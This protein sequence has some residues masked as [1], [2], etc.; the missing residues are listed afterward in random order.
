MGYR[1]IE[2]YLR[3]GQDAARA[4]G[5]PSV[6]GTPSDEGLQ[7][8]MSALLRTFSDFAGLWMDLMGKA[9]TGGAAAREP[10]VTPAVGTAGPFSTPRP[11]ED[12]E[13]PTA[14]PPILT[15]DIESARRIEVSVDLRI[16]SSDLTLRVHDLRA[17]ELDVPRIT[18]VTIEAVPEEER[19]AIRLRIPDDQP[20][21]IYNG[22]ILDERTGL[23]RGT[24][25][26]RIP[27]W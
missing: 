12:P 11:R 6:G 18:G 8:R 3:Q 25:C 27:P 17:P 16:R 10:G 26:V 9:S 22:I 15:L 14:A 2:E 20:S 23:P 13:G 5:V 19:V 1:V 4:M 21:G 7:N 24:L